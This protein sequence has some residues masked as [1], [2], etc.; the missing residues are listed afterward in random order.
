MS[1]AW[2]SRVFAA[3]LLVSAAVYLPRLDA[4]FAWDDLQAIAHSETLE[5]SIPWRAY[6]SPEYF[7]LSPYNNTWRPLSY[8][9][10]RTVAGLAGRRP[11]AHRLPGLLLH[12][13]AGLLLAA[14]AL[15]LGL[16][17]E[18]AA[19]AAA[20]FWLHP[21]HVESLMC[22]SH[23]STVLASAGLLAAAVLVER[24]RGVPAAGAYS[25]GMLAKEHGAL[26]LPLGWLA[27]RL[28]GSKLGARVYAGSA[29]ALGLYLA[30]RFAWLPGTSAEQGLRGAVPFADRLV[31]A[32]Q[33]W[34]VS[35]RVLLAPAGLRIEYF[36]VPPTGG[37]ERFA[38]GLGALLS[39]AGLAWLAWSCRRR[40]P[41][42][43]WGV[44]AAASALV[45]VSPLA[46][47]NVLNLRL[48]AER[49]LY[50]PA[51]GLAL[52]FARGLE[53]RR[54]VLGCVLAAWAALSWSRAGDW[55]EEPRLWTS[56]ARAYPWSSKAHE[57][58]ADAWLRHGRPEQAAAAYEA[59][60]RVREERADRVLAYYAPLTP[61]L[62]WRR[63]SIH[64]GLGRAMLALGRPGEAAAAFGRAI[65][66]A[67]AQEAFSFRALA[68]LEAERGGF[69][70]ALR[71]AEEGL[72]H[73]PGDEFLLRVAR[74]A[75]TSR[76]SFRA[77]F[78]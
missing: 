4:P 64:R 76:L 30:L 50:L 46:P 38:W 40:A 54:A 10:L 29:A 68:Y 26:G 23:L 66:A 21:V 45:L 35:W 52:A 19:W 25:V 32:A 36:A 56:L 63:S 61:E 22:A 33:A 62:N 14:L 11:W 27:Q 65:E 60:L 41:A 28:R 51:A 69:A 18:A 72:R 42:V 9:A 17:R 49:F 12:G 75:R 73:H 5:R 37:L 71:V 39:S 6:V 34:L 47:D 57:G 2:S 55:A 59:A 7:R 31:L 13:L 1:Q 48:T 58:A 53:G 78:D 77:R 16:G 70:Q 44:A 8:L 15:R 24:G 74:D 3:G 43:T 67:P 20:L